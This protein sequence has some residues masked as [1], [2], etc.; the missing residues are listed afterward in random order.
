[1]GRRRRRRRLQ[2]A[3]APTLLDYYY[4]TTTQLAL[5]RARAL[6]HPSPTCCLPT[7]PLHT[8]HLPLLFPTQKELRAKIAYYTT[9]LKHYYPT[10]LPH[11]HTAHCPP[12]LPLHVSTRLFLPPQEAGAARRV[13]LFHYFATL[14]HCHNTTQL[15]YCT[16]AP[17]SFSFFS[18]FLFFSDPFIPRLQTAGTVRRTLLI[19]YHTTTLPTA[20]LSDTNAP[21]YCIFPAAARGA[22]RRDRL[23]YHRTTTLPTASSLTPPCCISPPQAVGAAYRDR[24]AREDVHT[25]TLPTALLS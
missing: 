10:I 6:P 13:R 24:K 1:M 8:T 12:L 9:I 23:L 11:D 14:P 21:P 15:H 22:T 2:R 25:T 4:C 18:D 19:T 3:G 17:L 16:T 7:Q 5:A 20:F